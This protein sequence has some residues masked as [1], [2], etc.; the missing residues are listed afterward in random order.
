MARGGSPHPAE[1]FTEEKRVLRV[2][3]RK[4][5]LR[6]GSAPRQGVGAPTPTSGSPDEQSTELPKREKLRFLLV[7]EL[8]KQRV[9]RKICGIEVSDRFGAAP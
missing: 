3:F 6:S 4:E 1:R 2:K 5:S 9:T 7:C 8:R